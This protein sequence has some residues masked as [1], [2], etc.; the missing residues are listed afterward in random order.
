M[1]GGVL[2]AQC[3][4]LRSVTLTPTYRRSLF[5]PLQSIINALF[6]GQLV[7]PQRLHPLA[8][9][10]T[11][12]TKKN[13]PQKACFWCTRWGSNPDSTAS[14]AVMLSN[15]TTSTFDLIILLC[16]CPLCKRFKGKMSDFFV[17]FSPFSSPEKFF[18]TF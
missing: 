10:R 7:P 5:S 4:P 1:P 3:C 11:P 14:E 18:L 9:V 16:F 12:H 13:T 15:Y 2:L 6:N 8:V 17:V